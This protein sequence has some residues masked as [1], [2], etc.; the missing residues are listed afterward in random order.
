MHFTH[1]IAVCAAL[2]SAACV[3]GSTDSGR[4]ELLLRAQVADRQ[5]RWLEA[6]EAWQRLREVDG[7]ADPLATRGLARALAGQGNRVGA[8]AVLQGAWRQGAQDPELLVDLALL[9]HAQG[10]LRD[11]T[12][13]CRAA[14]ELAPGLV[15]AWYLMGDLLQ[16]QDQHEEALE[17]FQRA[18]SLGGDG[19]RLLRLAALAYE[20]SGDPVA[21]FGAWEASF[22]KGG[23][24]A[25]RALHVASLALDGP[26]G[27]LDD[28]VLVRLLPWLERARS[29]E[30]QR[31]E[32]HLAQARVLLVL[33]RQGAALEPLRRA[34]EADPGDLRALYL[35]AER[36]AADGNRARVLELVGHARGVTD[37]P[38]ELAPFEALLSIPE[39]SG[40]SDE[41]P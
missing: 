39:E 5:E 8:A 32:L 36:H 35:L 33:G 25:E 40:E 37:D 22:R 11:A 23:I 4:E 30:P 14:V 6:G 28:G 24:D 13:A 31:A 19:A 34:A 10:L 18:L 3:V 12:E 41:S 17:A 9:W 16:E 38:D 2:L 21:A 27:A 26:Q 15:R 1:P 29:E 20:Q 7:G